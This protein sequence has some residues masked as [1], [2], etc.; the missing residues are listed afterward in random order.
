M[1]TKITQLKPESVWQHFYNLTQIPRPSGHELEAIGYI[2]QF[3][4]SHSL[5]FIIDEPG[6][7]IVRKAATKGREKA[8]G[9]ILQTHVD[10]VPQK[11]SDKKHNFETDPIEALIDGEWVKANNTT[12]G[13]DNGIGVAAAL[14]L[15]ESKTIQHGPL[16]A[17]FTISEETGMDGAFGLQKEVLRGDILINLDSED[18]GELFIGCAGGVNV[19]VEWNYST[20]KPAQGKTFKLLLSG[21]KGGHSGIDINLGRGNASKLLAELLTELQKSFPVNLSAFHGGNLRNAIPREA[22]AIVVST[23]DISGFEEKVG[24]WNNEVNIR[25]K[26][27]ENIIMVSVE[28]AAPAKQVMEQKALN[29]LLHQLNTCPN[30]VITMSAVIPGVVQTSNNLSIVK[31]EEGKC[32]VQMLLRSSVDADR[33]EVGKIIEKHFAQTGAITILAGDYPGWQPDANSRILLKAK[34]TYHKIAGK[35]PEVK[36]I[37]AGLECGIIGGKYPNLDMISFGPTIR[38]P[39]SPDEKVNIASVE[40]FWDFLVKL[41]ESVN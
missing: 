8:P 33:T 37:H 17:L 39:H 32:D 41:L 27:I 36:V 26:D 15:L 34:E 13:A 31:V 21:L 6:N 2:K 40:R 10:M 7:I 3:A 18:E 35:M 9:I 1:A 20:V 29:D 11:N 4:I 38:H 22:E 14:A 28:E 5:E 23:E 24:K 16:E 19:N 30:G 12:L 25:F